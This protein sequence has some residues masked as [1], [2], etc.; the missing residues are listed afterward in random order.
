MCN[1][2]TSRVFIFAI[3]RFHD[4]FLYK[5]GRRGSKRTFDEYNNDADDDDQKDELERAAKRAKQERES[6]IKGEF[7]KRKNKLTKKEKEQKEKEKKKEGKFFN[8]TKKICLNFA[9]A[10][11]MY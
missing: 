3:F 10:H 7:D 1:I 11:A 4:F 8:F 2:L 9:F 5:G 6:L